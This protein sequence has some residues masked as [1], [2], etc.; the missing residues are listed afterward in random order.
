[1][2]VSEV[3]SGGG[4]SRAKVRRPAAGL[5]IQSP[6]DLRFALCVRGQSDARQLSFLGDF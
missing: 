3:V 2:D 5:Q 1:M 6:G 4:K